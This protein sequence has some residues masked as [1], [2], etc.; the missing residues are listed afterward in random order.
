LTI[1]MTKIPQNEEEEKFV[2]WYTNEFSEKFPRITNLVYAINESKNP[3]TVSEVKV[4]KGTGYMT[5]DILG[6]E[7]RI[8]PF[9]FF[10]TNS[11]QLNK[12]IS[13]IIEA[14]GITNN[15]NV[16]D[17]YCGTGSITLPAAN[18]ART[19][20]GIEIVESSIIDAREN[21]Y[22]NDISNAK[23]ICADLNN[24]KIPDL[25][26]KLEKPDIVICDPPRA[27][28]N[29]NLISHLLNLAPK[30]IVYVSCNP[31]TQARDCALLSEKYTI[32]SVQPVDMF[33]HTYHI[34]SIAVL[35]LKA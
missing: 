26:F 27:G 13:L 23:F 35:N 6:V 16:W 24:K 3:V 21:A 17:L 12:F 10:Q 20:T 22:L 30:R 25:L 29:P 14:A 32:E 34:E 8:S 15:M 5:E 28:M 4:L 9:S 33:P 31:A 19:I 7:Y 2:E 1:M 11:F 18:I